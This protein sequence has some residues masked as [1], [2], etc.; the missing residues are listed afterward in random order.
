MTIL[1]PWGILCN[2]VPKPLSVCHPDEYHSLKGIKP[3]HYFSLDSTNS[4]RVISPL[5][6]SLT[7]SRYGQTNCF[8]GTSIKYGVFAVNEKE[9]YVCTT[10]S[11]R[12]MAFQGI[13][14]V[15]GQVNQLTEIEGTKIVGTKIAA[16]FS[17]Y[18]EV[19][20]LPMENVLATKV[21]SSHPLCRCMLLLC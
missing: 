12:N 10:R 14:D 19:Y 8:V 2:Y 7:P 21:C 20:V 15:R 5:N 18:P 11:A 16:P 4:P 1:H 17:V 6:I 3:I 9:A 13:F